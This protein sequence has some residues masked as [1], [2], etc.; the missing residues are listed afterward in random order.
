M[1]VVPGTEVDQETVDPVVEAPVFNPAA[2]LKEAP[3]DEPAPLEPTPFNP[4][5]LLRDAPTATEEEDS[6]RRWLPSPAFL[7]R[8]G[9]AWSREWEAFKT[10]FSEG[11]GPQSDMGLSPNTVAAFKEIGLLSPDNVTPDSPV[12]YSRAFTD[13]LVHG[14][15]FITEE[16]FGTLTG[17]VKGTAAAVGQGV[18]EVANAAGATSVMGMEPETAGNALSRD[19]EN[20]VNM[21]GI[22]MGFGNFMRPKT[23]MG[24]STAEPIGPLPRTLNDFEKAAIV[25]DDPKV[26]PLFKRI[27]LER[28]ISPQEIVAD[29]ARD[30]TITQD[31]LQGRIPTAYGGERIIGPG[32]PASATVT[33]FGRLAREEAA[34]RGLTLEASQLTKEQ[35]A[36]VDELKPDAVN[37]P[38]SILND[39]ALISLHDKLLRATEQAEKPGTIAD[40]AL[41]PL[42]EQLNKTGDWEAFSRARGYSD[43]EIDQFRDWIAVSSEFDKRFGADASAIRANDL[44]QGTSPRPASLAE[45]EDR[46]LSTVIYDEAPNPLK[47]TFH[48]IYTATIDRLHPAVEFGKELNVAD[49]PYALMRLLNGSFGRADAAIIDGPFSLIDYQKIGPGLKEIIA[50]VSNDMRSFEAY[51]DAQRTIELEARGIPSGNDL[52]AAQYFIEAHPRRVEFE[53]ANKGVV[54]FQNNISNMLVEAGL[55]SDEAYQAMTEANR[56]YIPFY[57]YLDPSLIKRAAARGL[58]KGSISYNPIHAIKG[59]ELLHYRPIESILKNVYTYVALAERNIANTKLVDLL[60]WGEDGRLPIT[61]ELGIK[62][63]ALRLTR[64]DEPDTPGSVITQALKEAGINNT[65]LATTLSR[66]SRQGGRGDNTITIFRE[67]KPETYAVHDRTLLQMWRG[68]DQEAAGWVLRILGA[69]ARGLRLGTTLDPAFGFRNIIRDFLSAVIQTKGIVFS[70]IDTTKGAIAAAFK[71]EDYFNWLKGGGANAAM[72]SIDRRYLKERIFQLNGGQSFQRQAWNVIKSPFTSLRILAE[73]GENMTRIGEFRK[74]ASVSKLAASPASRRRLILEGAFASREVSID[75]AR[76]G[77]KMRAFNMLTAFANPT[78]QGFDRMIRQFRK[79][80]LTTLVRAVGTVTLPTTLL[81]FAQHND[82]RYKELP[83]TTKDLFWPVIF[84]SWEKVPAEDALKYAAWPDELKRYDSAGNLEVDTGLIIRIPKPFEYGMIFGTGVERVLEDVYANNPEAYEGLFNSMVAMFTPSVTPTFAAPVAEQWANRSLFTDGPLIP[85]R[86]EKLLPEYQN[87]MYTMG[88]TRELGRIFGASPMIQ[89]MNSSSSPFLRGVGTALSN[90][91]IMENYVRN[92]TGGLG[93]HALSIADYALRKAGVT[94]DPVKP[95]SVVPDIPMLDRIMSGFIIRHPSASAASVSEFYSRNE[96]AQ[97]FTDSLNSL[98]ANGDIRAVQHLLG[99]H[100]FTIALP[101][102]QQT[103]ADHSKLIRMVYDNPDIPADEKRQ[104]MD[105]MYYSMIQVARA[106]NALFD[107][108]EAINAGTP[109]AKFEQTDSW[110][111][112]QVKSLFGPGEEPISDVPTSGVFTPAPALSEYPG[113][114][115]GANLDPDLIGYGSGNEAFLAGQVAYR[116]ETEDRSL[117]IMGGEIENSQEWDNAIDK[118]PLED[119]QLV[120]NSLLRAE[121][122]IH[123]NAVASLGFEPRNIKFLLSFN[124]PSNPIGMTIH[125]KAMSNPYIASN[126]VHESI[127]MGF[128]RLLAEDRV[129]DAV[130]DVLDLKDLEIEEWVVR[131]IM[132]T[133]MGNPEAGRSSQVTDAIAFFEEKPERQQA[134]KALTQIA[135]KYLASLYPSGP[136]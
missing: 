136:R 12:F 17:L 73:F 117:R 37:G 108:I 96:A 46:I 36:A 105:N 41:A 107:K 40:P 119:R 58:A 115:E 4:A 43:A 19:I 42:F 52:M 93:L 18:T 76:M 47:Q 16:I 102:I 9:G 61:A 78:V 30:I 3:V 132:A 104:L 82:P 63:S 88:V 111:T 22:E 59:S 26:G 29:S 134:L 50:P 57:R 2:L 86:L 62:Q 45:A 32:T 97:R 109:E 125:D 67:G 35:L 128:N 64:I 106:G 129:P 130:L 10:A 54:E 131:Y 127:H 116:L 94:P 31:L 6:G 101:A 121:Y 5:S 53:A 133:Q 44:L 87:S 23:Y 69:P 122:A 20:M 21:V 110:F 28:G 114:T 39:K 65:N 15:G 103:L 27:W 70:P 123:R 71:T 48:D 77:S 25:F 68:M 60:K 24:I 90:P 34:S 66:V 113:T 84:P 49:Y 120:A 99:N 72:V 74:V 56:Y 51:M 95:A 112:R 11:Y 80:P 135:E 81:W 118:M 7:D 83:Q 85:H 8:I 14:G 91:I 98:A 33:D 100:K 92:W 38:L 13:P 55:V 124:G 126:L 79:A 1:P 75:F 89:N